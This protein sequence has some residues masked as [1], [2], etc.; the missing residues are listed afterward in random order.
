[1]YDD[2]GVDDR[3]RDYEHNRFHG[4]LTGAFGDA[5]D[6]SLSGGIIDAD[7][8]FG[9]SQ[10]LSMEN[11][12]DISHPYLNFQLASRVTGQLDISARLDWLQTS[13]KYHGETLENITFPPFGPPIPSFNYKASVNDTQADRYRADI[14]GNYFI[15]DRHIL[16]LGSEVVYADGEKSVY[17]TTGN[18]LAVQGHSGKNLQMTT[19]LFPFMG[20]MTGFLTTNL[21]SY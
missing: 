19:P 9:I 13:H 8:G 1:M 10:N 5:T 4:K 16:T 12:Q 3:N 21:N 17:D 6:F 7:T 18:L 14:S 2:K 11:Y 15:S 20:S